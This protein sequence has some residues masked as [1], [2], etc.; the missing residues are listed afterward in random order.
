M[1]IVV[2]T[3][4]IVQMF[5][6]RSPYARLKQVLAAGEMRLVVSTPIYLEYEEVV[7]RYADEARW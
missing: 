6:L 7:V 4:V 3:N 5:G 1:T 2:D